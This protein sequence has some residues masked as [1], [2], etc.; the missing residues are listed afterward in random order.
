[1]RYRKT[2]RQSL[3]AINRPDVD[4][5]H[6][7]AMIRLEHSTLDH[8][9]REDFRRE[10]EIAADAP[11]TVWFDRVGTWPQQAVHQELSGQAL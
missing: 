4:E 8:L 10:C 2:I 7:E 9:S 6:A 1:M 5:R 11:D 3:D